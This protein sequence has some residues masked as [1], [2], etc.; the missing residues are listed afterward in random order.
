MKTVWK[1]VLKLK[2]DPQNFGMPEGAKVVKVDVQDGE[3]CMWV[4]VNNNP[5]VR[6]IERTFAVTGT[7][8]ELDSGWKYVGSCLAGS[9]VWHIW[10]L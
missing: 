8:W 4:I 9:F 5:G 6:V 7:G 10:E 2:K 3:I 1:Y